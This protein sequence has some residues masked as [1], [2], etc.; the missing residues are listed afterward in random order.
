MAEA[1]LEC[2]VY[3]EETVFPVKIARDAK[4]SALQEAI[5]STLSTQEH[6]VPPRL[7]T[8]YLAKK[9]GAWLKDDDSVD[10]L[11]SGKIDTAYKK[12]RP[13]WKLN[14]TEYFGDFQLGEEEIH[15]LVELPVPDSHCVDIG[16]PDP[17]L[18]WSKRRGWISK[19][20][21]YLPFVFVGL[22]VIAGVYGENPLHEK[23]CLDSSGRSL[24]C[25]V[26]LIDVSIGLILRY[27]LPS[28]KAHYDDLIDLVN[29]V[30]EKTSNEANERTALLRAAESQQRDAIQA[31]H[32]P[33]MYG[34]DRSSKKKRRGKWKH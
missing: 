30:V 15:I 1:E 19:A 26:I 31:P 23:G 33:P 17:R 8:L 18:D 9:D 28:W 24:V 3:G 10:D 20:Q 4:V 6:A 32:G 11:L 12:M 5:A 16:E 13:S 14:K 22:A 2:A 21:W 25:G 7:V 27:A 29:E 34:N